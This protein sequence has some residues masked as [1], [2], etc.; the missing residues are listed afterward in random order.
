MSSRDPVFSEA[1]TILNLQNLTIT[2]W[3]EKGVENTSQ[4]FLMELR[5]TLNK[6]MSDE[7]IALSFRRETLGVGEHW[8]FHQFGNGC[9]IFCRATNA[10]QFQ[11]WDFLQI[12]M[13][14][15]F[16]IMYT[17][18]TR[19][20][21]DVRSLSVMISDKVPHP[22]GSLFLNSHIQGMLSLVNF[23]S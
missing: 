2:N 15:N 10:L 4:L 17:F 9:N 12:M 19:M 5:G 6:G 13:S 14:F 16:T 22:M 23:S 20:E 8:I 1:Y 7:K 18:Q 21:D 3:K 11:F